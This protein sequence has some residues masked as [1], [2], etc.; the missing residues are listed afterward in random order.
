M[1]SFH[2]SINV[3]IIVVSFKILD[4]CPIALFQ[5]LWNTLYIYIQY[6]IWNVWSARYEK[7]LR[8]LSGGAAH[9]CT[10]EGT[11]VKIHSQNGKIFVFVVFET[12]FSG[13]KFFWEQIFLYWKRFC[14]ASVVA[15]SAANIPCVAHFYASAEEGLAA[16][17]AQKSHDTNV[18]E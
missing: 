5:Q 13:N 2:L 6:W 15:F 16:G 9:L 7:A 11:P 1:L 3:I 12:N 4:L 10:L 17:E 18:G 14:E 8:K